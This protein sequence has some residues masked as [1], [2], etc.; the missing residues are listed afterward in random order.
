MNRLERRIID[1][2]YQHR[3]GHLSSNLN[4]V[5]IIDEIYSL[6]Q[7]EDVF[8]LSSGH[9]ALAWYVVLEKYQSKDAE[10]LFRELGVHPHRREGT[11][12]TVSTGS[13]GMGLTVAVGYALANTDR[14][15]HC[16]VS[17]GECG[18]GSI[19]EALR[20]IHERSL[21]NLHVYVNVNGM[22]AYDLIDRDYLIQRLRTF[23][24]RIEIRQTDPPCWPWA[25][26]VLTHYY[27]L[28]PQDYETL[29]ANDSVN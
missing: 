3:I 4:A 5:N 12:I 25:Q 10:Q 16:L 18:E 19:W 7:P 28:K 11:D 14:Q 29:C 15:V 6:K 1:I 26:G 22:I 27:V 17:D 9:A 2:S 8:I 21:T 13:L 23:L 24:P 20:F